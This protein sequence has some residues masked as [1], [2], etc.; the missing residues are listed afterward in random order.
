MIVSRDNINSSGEFSF[1]GFLFGKNFETAKSYVLS[2]IKMHGIKV[3]CDLN[4]SFC[5]HYM[6]TDKQEMYLFNDRLGMVDLF[7]MQHETDWVITEN[8][9]QAVHAAPSKTINE[10]AIEQL[11]RFG[12]MHFKHSYIKEVNLC[13][14]ATIIIIDLVTNQ[15]K[16]INTYWKHQP[17]PTLYDQEKVLPELV[18]AIETGVV[19]SFNEPNAA[20]A[21]AN[22]GGLDSRW[23]MFYACQHQQPFKAYTYAGRLKSDA[24]HVASKVNQYLNVSGAT[25]IPVEVNDFLPKYASKQM[26]NNPM[27]P[28]YSSWYYSAYRALSGI[29]I[30]INGFASTFFDAF[31][32]KDGA[33]DNEQFWKV[34]QSDKYQY[35]YDL[36]N[37]TGEVLINKIYR[38]PR[39][40]DLK[41]SF[42]AQLDQLKMTDLGDLCDTFDF[43]CRQRRLNK[44]EPWTSFYGAVQAR[45]PIMHH[46]AV[47]LSLNM[48]FELRNDRYLYKKGAEAVMG[49]LAAIRFERSPLG[50][51]H[52]SHLTKKMKEL[53]WRA[54]MKLYKKTGFAFGFK[55][56]HK[57]VAQWMLMPENRA[58]LQE[59]F[60][61]N[62][63]RFNERF[64]Q[65]F[66][67]QNLD[68]LIKR[69]FVFVS[70]LLAVFLFFKYLEEGVS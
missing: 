53:L 56:E 46:K 39:N 31:T 10:L 30:N 7:V 43:Y 52:H 23:N 21:T 34:D 41:D 8:Y 3:L 68:E 44:N 64:N 12:Y 27:L 36:Y 4:G 20:Y 11:L 22:S 1:Q 66:I 69:D 5:G 42:F 19:E 67:V 59:T 26:E 13:D 6:D 62:N 35:C 29:D 17:S 55:G 63:D 28:L 14:P 60:S 25:Y 48:S 32:Y 61:G 16:T 40:A 58:Y 15:I 37:E 54:D 18:D 24:I 57:N 70:S 45:S 33:Q 47:D 50:L 65:S 51:N 9:W 2:Q 49:K 38:S